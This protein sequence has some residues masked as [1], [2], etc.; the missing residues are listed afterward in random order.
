MIKN[1]L[2]DSDIDGNF[3]MPYLGLNPEKLLHWWI[4]VLFMIIISMGLT[5]APFIRSKPKRTN[6][7]DDDGFIDAQVVVY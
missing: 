2:S 7:H 3:P 4:I 6:T 1:I 5:K